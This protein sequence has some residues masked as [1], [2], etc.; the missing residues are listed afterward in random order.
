MINA[1]QKAVIRP[2]GEQSEAA[3][4]RVNWREEQAKDDTL[5]PSDI[6]VE[7]FRNLLKLKGEC[8]DDAMVAAYLVSG[9]PWLRG[10]VESYIMAGANPTEIC[11]RFRLYPETIEAYAKVFC[12]IEPLIDHAGS[13]MEACLDSNNGK[14]LNR[15]RMFGLR[16]GKIF[17]D[18]MLGKIKVLTPEDFDLVELR[19]RSILLMRAVQVESIPI[20]DKERLDT[21]MKI[22]STLARY[23]ASISER[24]STSELDAVLENLKGLIQTVDPPIGLPN[25]TFEINTQLSSGRSDFNS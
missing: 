22:I 11:S 13:L 18:W 15:I 2:I 17:L 21:V 10:Q 5:T 12:D 1:L 14:A 8:L 24:G 23:K 20:A 19:L 3:V 16:Y 9:K 4:Y 25:T 7:R 6:W